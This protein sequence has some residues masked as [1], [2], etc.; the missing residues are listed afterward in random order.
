M[1][2]FNVESLTWFRGSAK[3][4]AIKPEHFQVTATLAANQGFYNRQT[5]HSAQEQQPQ[6]QQ[7]QSSGTEIRRIASKSSRQPVL[8]P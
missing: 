1:L 2:Y 3:A 7:Q 5:I 4:F 6:Q 8:E